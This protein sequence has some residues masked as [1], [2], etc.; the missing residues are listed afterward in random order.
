MIKNKNLLVLAAI[1]I[2]LLAVSLAQ[3]SSHRKATTGAATATVLD[4]T[5]TADQLERITVALGE[6]EPTVELVATPTGWV[7]ASAWDSRAN[8]ER[9]D[10]LL[11]NLGDLRG[12]FRSE[13]E[14]VLADYGLD[15]GAAVKVRAFDKAGQPVI[16]LDIGGSPERATGNFIRRPD[17]P[18]VYLSPTNLLSHVGLYNGPAQP[19]SRHFLDMQAFQADRLA[20]DSL[21]VEDETGRR[22]MVKEFAVVEP[23]T[24]PGEAVTEAPAAP[25]TDRTTWEWKLTVPRNAVLAKTKADG[26]L[27]AAVSVRA[28]DV[29]DPGA[30]PASYG[31]GEAARRVTLV[32]EDGTRQTLAFGGKREADGD[33]QA[34]VWMRVEGDPTVWVV[35]QYAVDNIFKPVADLLPE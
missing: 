13:S 29:D 6:D 32:L 26:V 24:Q 7:I 1:L 16:A 18:A 2:V 22:E 8:P 11:R 12:E 20:V 9:V 3:K 33:R 19:Q 23:L 10:A 4:G 21:I 25:E 28:I 17:S 14:A 27:G 31:L 15:A 5:F 35:S 34:G 30:E